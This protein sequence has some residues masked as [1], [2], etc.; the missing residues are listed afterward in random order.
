[1]FKIDQLT[2]KQGLKG[3]KG[4]PGKSITGAQG[5]P[6]RAFQYDDFTSS[7]LEALKSDQKSALTYNAFHFLQNSSLWS[8]TTSNLKIIYGPYTSDNFY[9]KHRSFYM[10]DEIATNI[11]ATIALTIPINNDIKKGVKVNS[12]YT[13]RV[14]A[15]TVEGVNLSMTQIQIGTGG[16]GFRSDSLKQ[17]SI[18]GKQNHKFL[19]QVLIQDLYKGFYLLILVITHQHRKKF[20]Y[21]SMV[22]KK[23]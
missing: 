8:S 17:G 23:N 6:G 4:I 9:P 15:Y 21:M 11:Q 2:F 20:K 1:M 7:Q 16:W 13:L 3:D 19:K 10:I 18:D 22:L 14:E 5:S 12:S